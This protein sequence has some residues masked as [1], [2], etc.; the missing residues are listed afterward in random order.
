MSSFVEPGQPDF[1]QSRRKS[2]ADYED[3]LP[4][5]L[6]EELA[7]KGGKSLVM[8]DR[9]VY[10][11]HSQAKGLWR[12]YSKARAENRTG[13][14]ERDAFVECLRTAPGPGALGLLL[15]VLRKP[16]ILK[17]VSGRLHKTEDEDEI[18]MRER[19]KLGRFSVI[20]RLVAVGA[21]RPPWL[22]QFGELADG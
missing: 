13:E 21:P 10:D 14:A 18:A 15:N 19:N 11:R 4:A 7:S 2:E 6:H 5:G 20:E 1:P 9:W 12:S 17:D 16:E 22:S 8:D 3:V